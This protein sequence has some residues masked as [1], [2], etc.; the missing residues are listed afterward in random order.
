MYLQIAST[1]YKLK[2]MFFNNFALM[3]FVSFMTFWN[4][5]ETATLNCT[6]LLQTS[7]GVYLC[8]IARVTEGDKIEGA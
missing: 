5:T 2:S 8:M 4:K 7:D 1:I 6:S 3:F